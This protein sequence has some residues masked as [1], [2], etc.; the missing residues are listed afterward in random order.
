[1]A[2]IERMT[3]EQEE[4]LGRWR[5]EWFGIGSSTER[6]DRPRAEKAISAMYERIGQPAPRFFWFDS[7]ATAVL[8]ISAL[9][10]EKFWGE[11]AKRVPAA[12]TTGKRTRDSLGDSLRDS[13]GASLRDSLGA[14]L[15]ASLRAT[16]FWG[17]MESYWVAYYAFARDV[18]GVK[19]D[20][21]KSSDLDLWSEVTKSCG[22]WW[23]YRGLVIVS[24]KPE[25]VRWEADRER[26][27]L[28]ALDG[29]ALRYRD[30]WEVYAV[31]GLRV[32]REA[33]MD[34]AWLTVDRI[35]G[36]QNAELR[37]VYLDRYGHAK[38]LEDSKAILVHEDSCGQ[39]YRRELPG[40]EPLQ[41]VRV[42]NS[43]PE[44]GG[45]RKVY[46]LRVPPSVG[47][48]REG[49]AWTFAMDAERYHPVAES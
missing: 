39:L 29:P 7:P 10:D 44:P 20:A 28:H 32:P 8:G 48:A 35:E 22:W 31:R 12:V 41:M 5:R 15:W 11:A 36:E 25:S 19:Y 2:K 27:R 45:T 23:P 18:L 46:W 30:G 6:A 21:Q 34:P 37:R 42:I 9:K 49:V 1:M 13:L 33:I 16:R 26:P 14:S 38:Y 4:L 3:P 17:S 24:E 47:T 43:T 40:D